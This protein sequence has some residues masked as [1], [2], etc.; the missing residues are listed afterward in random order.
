M[1]S[2]FPGMDPYLERPDRW[3]GVHAGL[4]AV[5]REILSRQVAPRFFVDSEDGVYVLGL[6]DP[7]RALIW[8]DT[9]IVEA[10][11]AGTPVPSRERIAAPVLWI[12]GMKDLTIPIAHAREMVRQLPHWTL[13]AVPGSD[14]SPMDYDLDGFARIVRRFCQEK[15]I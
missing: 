15:T 1:R 2:P 6:D 7:A 14:H 3:G 5:V 9:Y 13:H 11:R 8:P 4:I 10:G 12:H